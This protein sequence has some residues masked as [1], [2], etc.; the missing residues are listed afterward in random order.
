MHA[1]RGHNRT[2][3]RGPG[4]QPLVPT[5]HIPYAYPL[6][7]GLPTEY[8]EHSEQDSGGDFWTHMFHEH[9]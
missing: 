6:K 1:A 3:A 8:R 4:A 5:L 2:C 7:D 9:D